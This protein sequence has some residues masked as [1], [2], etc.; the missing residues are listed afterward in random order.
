MYIYIID[1]RT[2]GRR[3]TN[4]EDTNLNREQTHTVLLPESELFFIKAWIEGIEILSVQHI[5][6]H[7]QSFAESLEVNDF[8]FS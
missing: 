1:K 2:P 3:A 7:S 5:L 4:K 8:S 6:N